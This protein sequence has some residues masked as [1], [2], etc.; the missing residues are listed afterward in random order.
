MTS[1][2]ASRRAWHLISL[3]CVVGV[4]HVA[5]A[6]AQTDCSQGNG[7]LQQTPPQGMS[8]QELIQKFAVQETRVKQARTGYTYTQEVRV[9]TLVGT[10]VDGEYHEIATVSYDKNGRRQETV[11]LAEQSTL[12]R[13]QLS[14]RDMDDI[15]TFMPLILTTDDLPQY[16]LTY[17]GQQQVDDLHAYVFYVEPKKME[18]NKHYFQGRIWVD[19]HDLAIVKVCGKSV[20]DDI[21]TGGK[22][23]QQ[24]LRP[25]FVTYRQPVDSYWFPAYTRVDDILHFRNASVHVRETIK[26]TGYKR[27]SE[28]GLA[29]P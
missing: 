7:P 15:R 25:T 22:K 14:A 16:K 12:R 10:S 20:P 11:T 21:R 3:L 17:T 26:F 28:N 23:Q 24:D 9:Q 19:D 8:E 29:G 18:E 2:A 13:I 1:H 4:I 6:R 27:A 5:A